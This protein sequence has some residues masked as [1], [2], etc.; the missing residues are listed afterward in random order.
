MKANRA[1]F[2]GSGRVVIPA[3]YR[4]ALGVKPGDQV[5]VILEDN[6]VRLITK[7]QAIKEAQEIVAGFVASDVSLVDEL[8]KERRE[9]ADRE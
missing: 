9:A 7:Q 4:K 3:E 5:I 6:A 1:T 2:D 8:L